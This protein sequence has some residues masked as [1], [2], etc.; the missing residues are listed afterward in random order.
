MDDSEVCLFPG[1]SLCDPVQSGLH[2]ASLDYFFQKPEHA[3]EIESPEQGS[4]SKGGDN[5]N[6]RGHWKIENAE[7]HICDEMRS[8]AWINALHVQDPGSGPNIDYMNGKSN[9]EGEFVV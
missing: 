2:F 6:D 8:A 1:T 9:P 3:H 7:W 4:Q 5:H